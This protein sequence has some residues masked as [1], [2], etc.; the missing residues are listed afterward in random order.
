MLK[1]LIIYIVNQCLAPNVDGIAVYIYIFLNFYLEICVRSILVSWSSK[2]WISN[3]ERT[4]SEQEEETY[5]YNKNL[6]EH[7]NCYYWNFFPIIANHG[8]ESASFLSNPWFNDA[9]FACLYI[10]I[11]MNHIN[12]SN[13]IRANFT[14]RILKDWTNHLTPFKCHIGRLI[15]M[16]ARPWQKWNKYL[17]WKSLTYIRR[18]PSKA[19]YT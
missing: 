2:L 17:K 13:F 5:I 7:H 4:I 8:F 12:Q 6:M 1:P 15:K 14:R 9:T 18:K 10:K 11:C 16:A 19:F 3:H